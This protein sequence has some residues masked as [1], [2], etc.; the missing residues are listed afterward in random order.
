MT[1]IVRLNTPPSITERAIQLNS[2][3]TSNLLQKFNQSSTLFLLHNSCRV[4]HEGAGA[5]SVAY[6]T[7]ASIHVHVVAEVRLSTMWQ[8]GG[9]SPFNSSRSQGVQLAE[10]YWDAQ[11]IILTFVYLIHSRQ[12][13]VNYWLPLAVSLQ[14]MFVKRYRCVF[15][16][17]ASGTCYVGSI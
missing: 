10:D 6:Y 1:K 7:T 12:V 13:Q 4:S 2:P 17:G 15:A 16:E 14:R 5:C 8:C 9:H 11:T 3:L